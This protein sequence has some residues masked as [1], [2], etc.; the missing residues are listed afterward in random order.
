MAA[1]RLEHAFPALCPARVPLVRIPLGPHPWLHPLRRRHAS[2][3]RGLPSDYG[4]V[5]LLPAVHH[6]CAAFAF[7]M[8]PT[9][10]RQRADRMG[11]AERPPGFRTKSV[12]A[13]LGSLTTPSRRAD[14]PMRPPPCGLPGLPTRPA[15]ESSLSRLNTRPTSPLANASPPASRSTAH[16]TGPMRQ[17]TP[18][19]YG[20]CIHI[21]LAGLPAHGRSLERDDDRELRAH[22]TAVGSFWWKKINHRGRGGRGE[23]VEVAAGSVW[24][25][26]CVGLRRFRG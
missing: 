26:C 15:L 21:L 2:F 11:A 17:A 12:S 13:C 3:V 9:A 14:P 20:T 6:R 16:G 10:Q 7:P 23:G 5:R 18:S 25:G 8:R 22:R 4:E 19:S 24:L 1:Q